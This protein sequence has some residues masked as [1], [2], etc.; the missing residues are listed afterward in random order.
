MIK[1]DH[2]RIRVYYPGSDIQKLLNKSLIKIFDD[3]GDLLLKFI[4]CKY[5]LFETSDEGKDI[6]V[7]EINNKFIKI[8]VD[9]FDNLKVIEEIYIENLY[10]FK[11]NSDSVVLDVGMNIGASSLFFASFDNIKKVYG[12]EPF[13]G[14]FDVAEKN[15]E[16]NNYAASKIERF[17]YGLGS[18][19]VTL[20]VPLPPNGSL[21]GST[22]DFVF[23]ELLDESKRTLTSV[24]IQGICENLNKIHQSE[25]DRKIILKLDCEGAEYEII[26]SLRKNNLI[27]KVDIFLIEYHLKGNQELIK[28]FIE[29]GFSLFAPGSPDVSLFGMLY[30]FKI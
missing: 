26:E 25:N 6:A 24:E 27:D 16:L 20:K 2:E 11:F 30:V 29:N 22:S 18:A 14:T 13:K 3:N 9:C 15:I 5:I 12:F 19:H 21:G 17:N 4:K 23:G 1:N 10:N 7:I 8:F 28:I